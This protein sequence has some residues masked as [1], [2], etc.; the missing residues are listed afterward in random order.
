MRKRRSSPPARWRCS[1]PSRTAARP[2]SNT[3]DAHVNFDTKLLHGSRFAAS[4]PRP[5][6]EGFC[7][8]GFRG[9][10]S[11]IIRAWNRSWSHDA[12]LTPCLIFCRRSILCAPSRPWRGISA[13]P[14]LRTSFASPPR[15]SAIRSVLLR[16]TG[17]RLVSPVEPLS[18]PHPRLGRSCFR[19]SAR[20][21]FGSATR[22][23]SCGAGR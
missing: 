16:N 8:R 23:R 7:R 9:T 12:L 5:W 14:R 15:R 22:P 13:S 17:R 21:S 1:R 20:R 4:I 18:H 6:Q 19:R 3:P 2:V 11:G 10:L